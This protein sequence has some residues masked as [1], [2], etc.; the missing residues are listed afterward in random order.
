[1]AARVFEVLFLG[2]HLRRDERFEAPQRHV[3]GKCRQFKLGVS[4][5]ELGQVEQ[6]IHDAQQV[7]LAG[8]NAAQVFLLR[9]RHRAA[10]A[11]FEQLDVARD[12]VEWRAQLVA[13]VRDEL[14]L[15]LVG[16]LGL[17]TL[18]PCFLERRLRPRSRLALA[19]VQPRI[20]REQAHTLEP[21]RELRV[22]HRR[23]R[24]VRQRREQ[25]LVLRRCR[26]CRLAHHGQHANH[27]PAHHERHPHEP[28]NGLHVA[29]P[30]K[31]ER[32]RFVERGLEVF[33][34]APGNAVRGMHAKQSLLV[35]QHEH[36]LLRF[37]QGRGTVG[38]NVQN[39][40][41]RRGIRER[42]TDLG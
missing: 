18:S 42:A 19:A 26:R 29:E 34:D 11:H 31:L 37:K 6:V 4:R 14:A 35:A 15:G 22:L 40:V 32:Q 36:R 17:G 7:P 28:V 38:G 9:V 3:H 5:L 8:A 33:N 2:E 16:A 13:H 24:L 41:E 23:G 39:L 21:L 10:Q 25:P 27:P 20:L 1:M 30:L 12:G